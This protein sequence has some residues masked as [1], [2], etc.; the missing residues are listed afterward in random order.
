MIED[1][2][3][4]ERGS[5]VSRVGVVNVLEQMGRA[6]TPHTTATALYPEMRLGF[7]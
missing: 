2:G 3:R 7:L 4:I 6:A 5:Q 1:V